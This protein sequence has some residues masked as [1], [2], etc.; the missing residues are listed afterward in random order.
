MLVSDMTRFAI[1]LTSWFCNVKWTD[2]IKDGHLKDDAYPGTLEV[3]YMMND[4]WFL[5]R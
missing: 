4:I 3:P 1:R 5:L 2:E